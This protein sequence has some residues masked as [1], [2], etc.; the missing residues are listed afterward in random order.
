[1]KNP[2]SIIIVWSKVI[3]MASSK[4]NIPIERVKITVKLDKSIKKF[5]EKSN[6]CRASVIFTAL[7]FS[8]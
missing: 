2:I 5:T 6:T 1:M 7:L 8:L 4:R 3:I